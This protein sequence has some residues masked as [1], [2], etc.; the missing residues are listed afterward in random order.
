MQFGSPFEA[1][2]DGI[3]QRP[4]I[5]GATKTSVRTISFDLKGQEAKDP[6]QIGIPVV[7]TSKKTGFKSSTCRGT[8]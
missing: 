8:F 3:I 6:I 1:K 2:D 4:A 7:V 5:G